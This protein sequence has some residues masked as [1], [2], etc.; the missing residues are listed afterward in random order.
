[1][2]L[3][4]GFRQNGENF[5]CQ[6]PRACAHLPF[7]DN[8][9]DLLQPSVLMMRSV[10]LSAFMR[11][12]GRLRFSASFVTEKIFHVVIAVFVFR[13]QNDIK[14]AAVNAAFNGAADF[15]RKSAGRQR[16]QNFKKK[17]PVR[18]EIQQGSHSHIA[19]DSGVA[20]KKQTPSAHPFSLSLSAV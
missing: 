12:H 6:P 18:S 14:I 13:I 17:P 4:F 3:R 16:F 9:K 2:N 1:M 19:A 5:L 7:I 8:G 10:P 11:M 15:H 20:F